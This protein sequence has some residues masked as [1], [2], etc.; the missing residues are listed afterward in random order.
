LNKPLSDIFSNRDSSQ[1][2]N[3]WAMK[4]SEYII[5]L[6]KRNATKSHVLAD[7]ITD[8]MEPTSYTEGPVP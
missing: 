4:L 6:K 5:N 1:R 2:I 3:K 7:F 8:W